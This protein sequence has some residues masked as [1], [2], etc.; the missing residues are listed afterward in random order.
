ME[1]DLQA[2][3]VIGGF[4]ASPDRAVKRLTILSLCA[5]CL[6]L[7]LFVYWQRNLTY[8]GEVGAFEVSIRAQVDPAKLQEWATNL[9]VTY[10]SS[11]I[12]DWDTRS[13]EIR[14]LPVDVRRVSPQSPIAFLFYNPA[15]DK[16]FIRI[17]WGSGGQGHW[18]LDV[19]AVAF[20][21]PYG[22]QAQLWK[23]GIYFWRQYRSR[24]Q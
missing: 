14:N 5:G 6:L 16:A 3:E 15:L 12:V 2:C 17:G 4:N 1:N 18:G 21:D 13:F 9:L 19:G 10:S 8:E 20:V 23:P 24:R 11:N 22:D 7:A